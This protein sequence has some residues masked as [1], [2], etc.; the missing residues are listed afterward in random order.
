M[1]FDDS[2]GA[3]S[4]AHAGGLFACGSED[5]AKAAESAGHVDPDPSEK[6]EKRYCDRH[7]SRPV[8]D[9]VRPD[10]CRM[11]QT[12]GNELEIVRNAP[13]RESGGEYF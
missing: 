5:Q 3:S 11:T 9:R 8:T 7:Q 4:I 13:Y 10:R 2:S 6:G 1:Q 12:P